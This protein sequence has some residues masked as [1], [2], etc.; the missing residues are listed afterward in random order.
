MNLELLAEQKALVTDRTLEWLVTA[1]NQ[2]VLAKRALVDE[3]AAADIAGVR[4]LSRVEA[5]VTQ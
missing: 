3:R 1:V 2:T 5:V 4:P